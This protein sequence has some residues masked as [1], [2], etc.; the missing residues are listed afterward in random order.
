[1]KL[2]TTTSSSSPSPPLLPLLLLSLAGSLA[3]AQNCVATA[4]SVIPAC[5]QNCIVNGA[6]AVGCAGT[7]FGCQCQVTAA[8]YAAVDSCVSAAC[9]SASYQ[10]V[11]DGA[12]TGMLCSIPTPGSCPS[13][14]FLTKEK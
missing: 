14:H 6:T 3:R 12:S 9:P 2:P 4:L 5:A 8:L 7:D 1:M 10:A 11:I 13:L